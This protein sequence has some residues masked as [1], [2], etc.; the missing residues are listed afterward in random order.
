MKTLFHGKCAYCESSIGAT[1][2]G[3]IDHFRPKTSVVESP[4]HPGYWWLVNTWKNMLIACADCN[5]TR[6]QAGPTEIG[7]SG[8]GNRFPLVD[9][10]KRAFEPGN[11]HF[12][13]PLLLDPTVDYPEM[14]FVYNEDGFVVSDTTQ[15]NATISVIGLNRQ[16]LVAAREKAAATVR[17]QIENFEFLERR[18]I[19]NRD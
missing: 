1:Q 9:E 15:G 16:A 19:D 13:E 8:K 14:H 12:E 2:A 6:R 11:E 3:D 18:F 17:L 4:D 5:R 7:K 10:S